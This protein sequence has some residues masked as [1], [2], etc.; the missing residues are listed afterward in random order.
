MQ[1]WMFASNLQVEDN[2]PR[3]ND[4][5]TILYEK[6]CR[7]GN[8]EYMIPSVS[9]HANDVK[10]SNSGSI[11]LRELEGKVYEITGVAVDGYTYLSMCNYVIIY[12]VLDVGF[13]MRAEIRLP[14]K[15]LEM[16]TRVGTR[17][18]PL[19]LT[20]KDKPKVLKISKGDFV[21]F[22]SKIEAMW[23]D[24]WAG[25]VY[26]SFKGKIVEREIMKDHSMWLLVEVLPHEKEYKL[27]SYY[28][29]HPL[30]QRLSDGDITIEYPSS[31]DYKLYSYNYRPKS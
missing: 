12:L 22:K 31:K 10:I 5:V 4:G 26:V 8:I 11:G 28:S 3:K 9:I 29:K 6:Y 27:D 21:T 7:V 14:K 16:K 18:V 13:L 30:S 20:E 19:T 15:Y 1:V 25:E 23:T 17:C 24:M 2:A